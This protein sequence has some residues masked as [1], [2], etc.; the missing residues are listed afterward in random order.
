VFVKPIVRDIYESMV[1]CHV[2]GHPYEI[3]DGWIDRYCVFN[4][5]LIFQLMIYPYS[6]VHKV[7]YLSI[8]CLGMVHINPIE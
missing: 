5:V 7:I 8:P 3:A 6:S 4:A 1:K 2:R